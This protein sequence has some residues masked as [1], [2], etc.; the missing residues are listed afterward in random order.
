M[1]GKLNSG[2]KVIF[3]L[4]DVFGGGAQSLIGVI[5]FVFLA[6]IIGIGAGLAGTVVMISKI[7]DAVTDPLMGVISDNT[8]SKFGRRK[9]YIFLGGIGLI[10]VFALMWLPI[11]SWQSVPAKFAFCLATYI[12]YSTISTV[13]AVPYSSLSAEISTDTKERNSANVLR[14]VMST[15]ATAICTILPTLVLDMYNSGKISQMAFYVIIAF[16][17]GLLFA[18]P[19]LLVGIFAKE[20]VEIPKEKVSFNVK[21]FVEPTKVKG[22]RQLVGMYLCQSLAMD[23]MSNG[24]VLY[25]LYCF[26]PKASST[27]FLGIFIG[28]QLLMFPIINKQVNKTDKNKVYY[29]GLPLSLVAIFFVAFYPS[30][31]NV[32]GAY[33]A[34]AFLALGFAGAQLTSWIIF[35]DAVDAGELQLGRRNTGSF[36][37]IMTFIRKVCSAVAIWLFGI[38]LELTGYVAPPFGVAYVQ[39][40]AN[41]I[42]GI[43]IV[44]AVGFFVLLTFGYF[45]ARKF[46]LTHNVSASVRKFLDIKTEKRDL[47]PLEKTEFDELMSKL[48]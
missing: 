38:V 40:P 42:L 36:S 21:T 5:Y 28:V 30:T 6:N 10:V 2:E 31:W 19:L 7:W 29:F 41:A 3:A 25:A 37:G 16:G 39:Q 24:I 23:I 14:L 18:L 8:R 4:G 43:R 13:I 15:G 12:L 1:K 9:P 33:I 47:T 26:T 44:M 11:G 48:K 17:F 46:I 35:P 34:T 45:I 32:F 22:F 20:R 27:V